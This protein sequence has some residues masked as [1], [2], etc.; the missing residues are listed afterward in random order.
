MAGVEKVG[1]LAKSS[2]YPV[3]LAAAC[4]SFGFVFVHP[5]LDGNGRLHRFLLHHLYALFDAT[6]LCEFT[7]ACPELAIDRDLADELAYRRA[8]DSAH[9]SLTRWLDAPQPELEKLIRHIA[10]NN[11]RFSINKR[12][13]LPLIGDDDITR[14][15]TQVGVAFTAYWKRLHPIEASDTPSRTVSL[16]DRGLETYGLDYAEANK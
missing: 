10:Q 14:A 12:G 5:F 9:R 6:E 16:G 15:E 3:V 11:G 1:E 7:F 8:Y 2:T 4:A 13:Q